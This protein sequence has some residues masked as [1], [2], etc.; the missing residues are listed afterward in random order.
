MKKTLKEM[1]IFLLETDICPPQIAINIILHSKAS[2]IRNISI[3]Y[4]SCI[5]YGSCLNNQVDYYKHNLELYYEIFILLKADL[6]N[7]Q[8]GHEKENS[9]SD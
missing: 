3:S 2:E 6:I 5:L 9:M 1:K 8:K 7:H 4:L